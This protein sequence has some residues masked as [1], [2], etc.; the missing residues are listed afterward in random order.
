MATDYLLALFSL[1]FAVILLRLGSRL[2]SRVTVYW[3][4]VFGAIAAAAAAGGTAHGLAAE[5]SSR[6]H[7]AIWK[8]AVLAP[9]FAAF[10]LLLT[11]ARSI[12]LPVAASWLALLAAAKL[13]V[14]CWWMSSH[15]EFGWVVI[16]Y[17][18]SLLV[19]LALHLYAWRRRGERAARWVVWGVLVSFGAAAVQQGGLAPAVWFNHN[20]LYHVIQMG[21]NYLLFRGARAMRER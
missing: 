20:D 2:S 1:C 5:L 8:V 11:S 19:A 18:A 17:G 7:A 14:Y 13:A 3:G 15:D 21:A 9:G 10:F 4:L 16:D 12:L 6:Q